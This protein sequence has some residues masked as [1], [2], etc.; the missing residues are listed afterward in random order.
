MLLIR[1]ITKAW[2]IELGWDT[3]VREVEQPHFFLSR[4]EDLFLLHLLFLVISDL[5]YYQK[6]NLELLQSVIGALTQG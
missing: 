1:I 2:W 5:L 6:Q 4:L 3:C